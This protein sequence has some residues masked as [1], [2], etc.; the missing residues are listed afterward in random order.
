MKKKPKVV[1]A[2]AQMW[3][4]LVFDFDGKPAVKESLR[5]PGVASN[6]RA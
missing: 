5:L 4:R 2:A 1:M 6:P 3:P